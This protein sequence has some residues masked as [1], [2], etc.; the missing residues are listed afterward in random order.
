L[1]LSVSA[2]EGRLKRGRR[3]LRHALLKRG[4]GLAVAL[5]ALR[6]S[7][8]AIEAAT[9][10]PLIAATTK[11]AVTFAAGGQLPAGPAHVVSESTIKGISL[12]KASAL[13]T[14][15]LGVVT[16]L[17]LGFVLPGDEPSVAGDG[18]AAAVDSEAADAPR[19]AP[20]SVRIVQAEEVRQSQP[21]PDDTAESQTLTAEEQVR[22]LELQ[23]EQE[24]LVRLKAQEALNRA[25]AAHRDAEQR[26]AEAETQAKLLQEQLQA[27]QQKRAEA[28]SGP[29]EEQRRKAE[30]QRR[31]AAEFRQRQS[32]VD[33]KDRRLNVAHIEAQL[34]ETMEISLLETPLNEAI[35]FIS[36]LHDIPIIL[37]PIA[38]EEDG[39]LIDE[40]V[41]LE[42]AGITLE[43]VL[44][45]ML[46]PLGAEWIIEDEVMKIT[47]EVAAEEKL[48][49]RVYNV[50][51]LTANDPT[52]LGE[53]IKGNVRAGE[54]ETDSGWA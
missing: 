47:T 43:S 18:P 16:A 26:A 6:S 27:E 10:Q 33:F 52:M 49:T 35:E 28:Q 32:D 3:Q 12:M 13:T 20:P 23:L 1:G 34:T 48:E 25:E 11:A 45:L 50:G 21:R 31:K 9:L 19:P 54:W 40:P 42:L 41:T 8:A 37:D 22:R 24:R 44:D 17:T 38:L 36:D 7:Q 2:V 15:G 14:L 46:E 4:V 5:V 51:E 39:I 53:V 30:E 29:D